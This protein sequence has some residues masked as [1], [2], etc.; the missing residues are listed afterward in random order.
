MKTILFLLLLFPFA[1]GFLLA[2]IGRYLPRRAAEWIGCLSVLASL[3]MAILAFPSAGE[4]RSLFTLFDWIRVGDF[5]ASMTVSYDPLAAIMTLMVTFVSSLIHLYS[6][7][8]MRNDRDY[9]RYFCYM[10]FFVFSMLVITLADNLVFLYLGWEGVGFCSYSLIGFWYSDV[11][12]ATAGRKAFIL[13]RIGDVAFGVAIALFFLFLNQFSISAINAKA[14]SLN[15]GTATLLALLLFWGAVGKSAQL[16]LIVWLPDA[17]A[18]PTPVSALIH[19][20]TMVTAG[21]YLLMRLFPVIALSPAALLTIAAVAAL[22]GLFS[23]L[24]ALGQKDIKRI[25]A[26]STISQVSYMFLGVGAGD[27]AGS[28]AH[29]IVHAFFKALLFLGAG[30][31]IQALREEHDIFKMGN[32]RHRLPAVFWLYLAGAVSLG[33]IP[34][35]GSFFGKDRI[36][37]STFSHPEAVYKVLAVI[38]ELGAVITVL[39]TFRMFFVAFLSRPS[40]PEGLEKRD[41]QIPKFMI[42]INL[43]LAILAVFA[44]GLD[45]PEAFGGRA[46]LS[47]YLASVPGGTPLFPIS[48][49]FERSAEI[50][51]GLLNI[52]VLVTAYFVYRPEGRFLR[53]LSPAALRETLGAILFHGFYLDRFYQIALVGPYQK[54]AEVLWS[55][56]DERGVD[57]LF[58]DTGIALRLSSF[59]L[60]RWTTGRLSTYL[61]MLLLGLMAIISA[62]ALGWYSLR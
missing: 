24:A 50:G 29:L 57:H 20:A 42:W 18:G 16:P 60:R 27:V 43:P 2:L 15:A 56:V 32:L 10:N 33:A 52:A 30:C 39:Y 34:P 1:G 21:A 8:F 22:T 55:K 51:S 28:M 25:L 19:A 37:L 26:Y 9:V 3:L 13:T 59:G 47:R 23:A 12:N 6:V 45:F 61:K 35:F 58:E 48:S 17:M 41:L 40:A 36:L 46:W 14:S 53:W 44:A 11:V 4:K 5:S 49:G 7:S 54:M 31:V 38:G 62:L